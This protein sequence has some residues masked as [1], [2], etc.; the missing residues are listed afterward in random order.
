MK[1]QAVMLSGLTKGQGAAA[2]IPAINYDI[3]N[4]NYE[5]YKVS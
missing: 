3:Q 1:K 5:M 2:P 4:T